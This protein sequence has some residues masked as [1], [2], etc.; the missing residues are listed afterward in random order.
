RLE[1]LEQAQ[2]KKHEKKQIRA[3]KQKLTQEKNALLQQIVFENKML[4]G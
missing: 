1:T 3:V 2:N 4:K